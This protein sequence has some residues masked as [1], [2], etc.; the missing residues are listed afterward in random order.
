MFS[1]FW[2][3]HANSW[4]TYT[5]RAFNHI[6]QPSSPCLLIKSTQLQEINI[7]CDR[8]RNKIQLSAGWNLLKWNQLAWTQT[9]RWW[10]EWGSRALCHRSLLEG[11][12]YCWK[13]LLCFWNIEQNRCLEL[14]RVSGAAVWEESQTGPIKKV[15]WNHRFSLC[16]Q[17]QHK[18]LHSLI[19]A[20][21]CWLKTQVTTSCYH[22]RNETHWCVHVKER[23]R[24]R[25]FS[26]SF[27]TSATPSQVNPK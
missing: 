5:P 14:Q 2:G 13:V 20:K 16:S 17:Q 4:S 19:K 11:S 23:E 25:N 21:R 9:S 15:K 22:S 26:P 12:F 18:L 3:L 6:P 1:C 8:L 24:I 27:F 10:W 7:S